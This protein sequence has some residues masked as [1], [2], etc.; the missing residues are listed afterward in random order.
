MHTPVGTGNHNRS[1]H[2]EIQPCGFLVVLGQD[3]RVE[4]VSDNI[5][6]LFADFT[7][8]TGQPLAEFF[9]AAAVHSLRNQLALMR[10]PQGSARLFSLI[11]AGVPKPFD[12][13]MHSHDGRIILEALPA[14]RIEAGDPAGTARQLAGMLN[15]CEN[16][17]ELLQ[18]G[19]LARRALTGYDSVTIYRYDS[20]GRGQRVAESARGEAISAG[21]CPAPDL[22]VLADA[23]KGHAALDP[24]ASPGIVARALL[25]PW[26]AAG[27][28]SIPAE[29]AAA[30]LTLPLVSAG[31][32]WGVALCL[33]R[34]AR[35]PTLERIAAA[36]LF[37]DMLAMRA[38]LCALRAA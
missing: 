23:A 30:C 3:W 17:A 28:E 2:A 24:P 34:A 4:H 6:A 18:R 33:S 16:V 13:A 19:G 27:S 11:F 7:R 31:I 8:M 1:A 12:V 37:A 21:A 15:G 9:G 5:G 20:G 29:S 22:R 36:E 25:R 26:G 14:G 32:P 10:D 38:E 35:P